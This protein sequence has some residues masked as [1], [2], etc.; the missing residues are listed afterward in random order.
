MGNEEI[1]QVTSLKV[2]PSVWKKAKIAAIQENITLSELFEKAIVKY[3]SGH[4]A[5]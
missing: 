5:K 4:T 2:L 3:L 1:R